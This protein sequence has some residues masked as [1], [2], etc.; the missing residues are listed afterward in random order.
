MMP[1]YAV[2][3]H[4]HLTLHTIEIEESTDFVKNF[5]CVFGG[6]TGFWMS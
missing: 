3:V 6:F 2:F 5:D 1:V 4:H